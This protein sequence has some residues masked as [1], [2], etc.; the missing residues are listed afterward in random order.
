[1]DEATV[2]AH[3]ARIAED[4]YTI[5]ED[6]IEPDAAR[7]ARRRP[8]PA[9]ARPRGRARRRTRSRA[10]H[11]L[12]IYNLLAHGDAVRADPGA[13]R[14]AADRRGRAR[15]RLPRLVA[16]VDRASSPA[17][18]RSRST[19]TTSSSRSRS[20]T[21]RRCAT[22]CGRSPTSPRRTARRASS[23][24][25]TS[26]TDSPTT[27]RDATTRSRPRCRRAACSSGTA[28]SGTAAARTRTDERRIGIAMNYC[29]GYIRQQENQQLGI[30]LEI[31]R[32]FSPRLRELVG[33]GIYNGLIGHID[34]QPPRKL[35]PSDAGAPATDRPSDALGRHRLRLERLPGR[36]GRPDP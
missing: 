11:T 30:P 6:A 4:G 19:P 7:R 24:A 31:A 35:L 34:K 9:R 20:R 13:R 10:D 8:R 26:P 29:A 14:R 1:M 32:G 17:R 12:R 15:P 25:R 28:A 16:V 22:R 21:R 18:P 23:P 33:Y 36:R 27:A 3:V 5:V 2:A